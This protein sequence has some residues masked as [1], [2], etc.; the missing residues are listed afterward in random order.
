MSW[1]GAAIDDVELALLWPTGSYIGYLPPG[2]FEQWRDG[3]GED[4]EASH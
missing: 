3:G 1:L 4:V 2:Q